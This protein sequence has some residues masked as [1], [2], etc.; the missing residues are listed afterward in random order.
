MSGIVTGG[1]NF[2]WAAYGITTAGLV[3]YG[4]T[5]FSRLRQERQR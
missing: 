4:I 1:W 3:I 5:L 2:V